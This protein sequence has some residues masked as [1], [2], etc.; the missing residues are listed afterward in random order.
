MVLNQC[1][2]SLQSCGGLGI[3]GGTTDFCQS[4]P[5]ILVSSCLLFLPAPAEGELSGV[6]D[7]AWEET[8]CT[9]TELSLG[10]NVSQ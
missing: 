4:A 5:N 10:G 2:P 3:S 7:A 1:S 9:V 6:G 8:T